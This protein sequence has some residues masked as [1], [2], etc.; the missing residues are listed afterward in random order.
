MRRGHL[1]RFGC[2]DVFE[3][4]G[5]GSFRKGGGW[6]ASGKV[7]EEIESVSVLRSLFCKNPQ[8]DFSLS[9][10]GGLFEGIFR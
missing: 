3:D 2:L 6:E 9:L 1:I 4:L 8:R 10:R 7:E 5:V